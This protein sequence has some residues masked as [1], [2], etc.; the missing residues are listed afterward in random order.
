MS[1]SDN[2]HFHDVFSKKTREQICMKKIHQKSLLIYPN[3]YSRSPTLIVHPA[4]ASLTL[5]LT[6][7]HT[8]TGMPKG[9]MISHRN[10][11]A[12][13]SGLMPGIP[14]ATGNLVGDYYVAYLP[15]AHIL[16]LSA[17]IGMLS[18][19]GAI[20]YGSTKVSSASLIQHPTLISNTAFASPG[21]PRRSRTPL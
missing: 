18:R 1:H 13:L 10:I 8:G 17:E 5:T 6:L 14:S 3:I 9:V 21:Q 16:E 20:G 4:R 7:V 15:L 12:A 19:G 2:D 11:V